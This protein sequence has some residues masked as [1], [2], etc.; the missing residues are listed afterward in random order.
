MSQENVEIVKRLYAE[1]GG[2][3]AS[4]LVAAD[5][6]LDLTALYFDQPVLRGR[7]AVRTHIKTGPWGA[8]LRFVPQRFIDVDHER[9]LV[10][11]RGSS[12]GRTSSVPVE[13]LAAQEF[14]I[15]GGLVRRT[16]VYRTPAEALKAVG[17][18]E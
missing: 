17:L 15:R 11:V 3:S 12:T 13:A 4:E 7:D 9:V 5:F 18:E 6:E 2:L 10:V 16:K 8:S 1:P 14:T